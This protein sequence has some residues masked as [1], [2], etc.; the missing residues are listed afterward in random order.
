MNFAQRS[1]RIKIC[2]FICSP[3]VLGLCLAPEAYHTQQATE[4]ICTLQRILLDVPQRRIEL[5]IKIFFVRMAVMSEKNSVKLWTTD[6]Y[7]AIIWELLALTRDFSCKYRA[8][9]DVGTRVLHA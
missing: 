7:Q 1:E 3:T 5:Y 4:V 2:V 9:V 6:E 8:H